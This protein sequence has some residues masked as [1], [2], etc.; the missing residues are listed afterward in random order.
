MPDEEEEAILTHHGT[1]LSY[2]DDFEDNLS[3]EDDEEAKECK[4]Y[5]N[6]NNIVSNN[7]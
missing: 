2:V 7:M 1:A 6:K 4:K 3:G 5:K